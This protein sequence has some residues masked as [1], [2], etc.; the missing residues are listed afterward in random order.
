ME[1]RLKGFEYVVK[2]FDQELKLTLP[3]LT[4]LIEMF[5]R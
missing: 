2:E 4:A 3:N 5:T 1:F